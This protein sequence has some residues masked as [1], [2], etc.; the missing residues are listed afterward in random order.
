MI[1]NLYIGNGC[2]TKHPFLNGCLGFQVVNT[3]C[4]FIRKFHKKRM[5]AS[6]LPLQLHT[7]MKP[8]LHRCG[9]AKKNAFRTKAACNFGKT[10]GWEKRSLE[11]KWFQKPTLEDKNTIGKK[12]NCC[13]NNFGKKKTDWKL[14]T[15]SLFKSCRCFKGMMYPHLQTVWSA[16]S[17][18]P[19]RMQMYCISLV[20]IFFEKKRASM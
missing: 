2:F 8:M 16:R 11:S 4:C 6:I 12:N 1:P 19:W 10:G 14:I 13:L 3:S 15:Y 7:M 20:N 18:G 17:I 9:E 5:L